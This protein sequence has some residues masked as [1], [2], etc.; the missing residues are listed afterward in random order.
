MIRTNKALSVELGPGILSNIFDGIQRPLSKIAEITGDF[1]LPRGV[2][3]FSLDRDKQW[4]WNPSDLKV[5]DIISGGDIIGYCYENAL[6]KQHKIL[7]PPKGK[8]RIKEIME[9]GSY[10]VVD[11]V[12]VVEYED[13]EVEYSMHHNW[14]VRQERPTAE[15]LSGNVPLLTGQRVLDFLFPS[16]LGGTCAIP[17][18]FG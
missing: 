8:G 11:P 6:F 3:V 16:I 7:I 5:G 4:D 12:I 2:D 13:K 10:S 17:G 14:P 15:R 18:A 1:S 9:A